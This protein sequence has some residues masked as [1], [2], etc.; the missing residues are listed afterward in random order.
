MVQ[1]NYTLN[2]LKET[3]ICG[4]K[5]DQIKPHFNLIKGLVDGFPV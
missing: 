2:E 4:L 3:E 1:G 5:W